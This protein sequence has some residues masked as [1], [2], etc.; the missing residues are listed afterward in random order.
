[1]ALVA[2][3]PVTISH[4]DPEFSW[5]SSPTGHGIRSGSVSGSA[6]WAAV[7]TLSELVANQDNRVT[8]AG[9]TGVYEWLEF[10]DDLLGSY[11]G[12]YLLEGFALTPG[13]KAS[14]TTTDVPFTLTAAFLGDL[15]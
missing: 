6:S 10:D 15:A 8:K 3:G 14:L 7:N 2:I 13:H 1:M 11:T 4:G 12:Y 9:H 5:D